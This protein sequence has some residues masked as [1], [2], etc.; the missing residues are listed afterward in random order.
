V[1]LSYEIGG[2]GLS[3][4]FVSGE[5]PAL[6]THQDQGGGTPLGCVPAPG[7]C[8]GPRKPSSSAGCVQRVGMTGHGLPRRAPAPGGSQSTRRSWS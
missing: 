4:V 3:M 2:A 5:V 7:T 1:T 6:A 8:S